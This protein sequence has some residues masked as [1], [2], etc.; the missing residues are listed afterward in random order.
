M[1]K[2]LTQKASSNMAIFEEDDLNDL[3]AGASGGFGVVSIRGGKWRAKF[4]GEETL[5]TN[6]E[7]EAVPSVPLVIVKAS[8]AVSKIFY[9]KKYEEGDDAAPDCYSE[10]GVAPDPSAPDPQHHECATC[11]MAQWGS[12]IS[13]YSG[14][15]V[16]RCN[17]SRRLVVVPAAAR[18][19]DAD[20]D[21]LENEQYGG[22]ML[23]RVPPAS[24]GDLA[25]Y[26]RELKKNHPGMS[27][28][29]IVTRFGF[30][31]DAD[32]P[33]LTF[34]A[35]RPLSDDEKVVVAGF[36]DSG[37]VDNILSASDG[38]AQPAAKSAA[39]AA[40]KTV[41]TTFEEEEEA[42]P[43][44][45]RIKPK[46]ARTTPKNDSGFEEEEEAPPAP[47]QTRKRPTPKQTAKKA[48]P[49]D[50]SAP[51]GDDDDDD[52]VSFIGSV[53]DSLGGDD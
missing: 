7:G 13:E 22:P 43:P 9:A 8:P 44:K 52:D 1:S 21:V 42:P 51:Q 15:K 18:S 6:E 3:T 38:L 17:D 24:I 33:K 36:Y 20:P 30:S 47:K 37:A 12:A 53:V 28:K 26:A 34:K 39:P 2:A 35:V 50:S 10:D 5:I 4:G 46:T 31:P 29:G 40:R 19:A 23:L 45:E 32:Y 48:P 11:P 27:Y 49:G 41:D 25:K 16:K 14:K